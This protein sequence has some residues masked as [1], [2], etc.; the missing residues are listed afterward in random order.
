[1]NN[2]SRHGGTINYPRQQLLALQRYSRIDRLTRRKLYHF[3]ILQKNQHQR[4]IEVIITSRAAQHSAQAKSRNSTRKLINQKK[5]YRTV[6]LPARKTPHNNI[7]VRLTSR[8]NDNTC[9]KN[10][11][12]ATIQN[13]IRIK[14]EKFSAQNF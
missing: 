7:E 1:M 10:R 8:K 2:F 11:T 5:Y 9:Y 12:G 6:T 4:R 14:T 13:L 3:N